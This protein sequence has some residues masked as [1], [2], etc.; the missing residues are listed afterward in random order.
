M[1]SREPRYEPSARSPFAGCT[2][3][4]AALLVMVFLI[5]FSVFSLF[6][7]FNEIAK[8]THEQPKPLLVSLIENQ[9]KSLNDLAVRLEDFRQSLAGDNEAILSIT[10]D[11]INLAI[12]AYEPFKDLRGTFRVISAES[13]V[14]QIDI[15][16]PI[17]GK[18][19][20]ARKDEVG[21]ITSDS[22]Y[23][24]ATMLARPSLLNREMVLI[25]ED[26][27]VTDA[28]VPR[29]FI[30]QMSPYRI[31]ERYATHPIL[32]PA[33]AQ[34][35]AVEIANGTLNL[36]RKPGEL[37]ADVITNKQVDAASKNLFMFLGIAACL[38]LLFASAVIFIGLRNQRAKTHE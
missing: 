32:G 24:N 5:G 4:I 36:S 10:P 25:I 28:S 23:L 18:P 29:E 30:E 3:L 17:N 37:P 38:F 15:S 21:W 27:K 13:N 8:F 6:R 16:F 22:R 31:A 1:Q 33:M 12:A 2:I 7:Q 14:L 19:R 9:E 11:D 35:S 20:L 26:I 34:L